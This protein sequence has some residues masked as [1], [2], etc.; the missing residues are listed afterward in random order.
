[1]L[2]E[3]GN[4]AALR[5]ARLMASMVALRGRRSSGESEPRSASSREHEQSQPR[6]DS[7]ERERSGCRQD[8]CERERSQR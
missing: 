2:S 6:W 1:M 7:C 3:N 5:K 8:S 4:Q